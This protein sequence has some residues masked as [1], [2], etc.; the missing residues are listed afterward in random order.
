MD[1]HTSNDNDETKIAFVLGNGRSRLSFDIQKLKKYGT[2]YGCNRI[3]DDYIPDYLVSVDKAMIDMLLLDD[4][5][6]KTK[7]YVDKRIYDKHYGNTRSLHTIEPY[8]D[9]IID[10]GNLACML[11]AQHGHTQ[12]YMIGFDY[13][14]RDGYHNNVYVGKKPYKDKHQQHTLPVSVENWYKKC[15]IVINRYDKVLFARI[16]NNDYEPPIKG[17]NFIN[18]KPLD[19]DKLFPDVYDS[20]INIPPTFRPENKTLPKRGGRVMIQAPLTHGMIK[21]NKK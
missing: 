13:I 21:W 18:L 10:S 6:T 5:Q 1:K 4:I 3:Y 14:S 16:N 7:I 15:Q 8:V 12:V 20:D 17:L 9:G 19:F 2:V 11:A